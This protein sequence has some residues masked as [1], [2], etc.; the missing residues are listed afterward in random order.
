[1]VGVENERKI[2]GLFNDY[3]CCSTSFDYQGLLDEYKTEE[4]SVN[5]LE[6]FMPFYSIQM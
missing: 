1:M 5:T 6:M 3:K 2:A 4:C